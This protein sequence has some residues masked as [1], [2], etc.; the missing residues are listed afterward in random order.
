[1]DNYKTEKK[2][3]QGAF[4]EVFLVSDLRNN[5]F[6]AMKMFTLP[7]KYY[8]NEIEM[9]EHMKEYCSMDKHLSCLH[10]WFRTNT[11]LVIV[12][13]YIAGYDLVEYI[14]LDEFKNMN[15]EQL[16]EFALRLLN[17]ILSTLSLMNE[18]DMV[19][20]DVKPGNIIYNPVTGIFTLIDYGLSCK[21]ACSGWSGTPNYLP[22]KYYELVKT[23]QT[24][25]QRFEAYQKI[26]V[27]ALG[28]AIFYI[29]NGYTPF[30]P[31]PRGSVPPLD[32]ENRRA[33]KSSVD[34]G[35]IEMVDIMLT[36]EYTAEKIKD[37]VSEREY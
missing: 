24:P 25:I 12:F 34:P 4:G 13:D 23:S 11:S 18:Y 22:E 15:D 20:R 7:S 21:R 2:L 16:N 36:N 9:L 5:K 6:Y 33:W 3:G 10:E 30:A 17:Q 28:V 27:Y 31:R 14:K 32:Y 29:T 8:R 26:D 19:H 1:M 35:L 37:M